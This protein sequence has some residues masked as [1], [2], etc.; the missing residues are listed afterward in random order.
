MSRVLNWV[1]FFFVS[2]VL[3]YRFLKFGYTFRKIFLGEG[4]YTLV[5]VKDYFWLKEYQWILSG[6]GASIYPVTSKLAGPKKTILISMHR[7]IMNQPKGFLVDH[8][9][10]NS[11]DNRRQNLRLATDSQNQHNK[12]KT[13]SK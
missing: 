10:C 3:L 4:K 11:L 9:N 2:P 1:E 6:N 12:K 8:R 7:M 5:D 13:L